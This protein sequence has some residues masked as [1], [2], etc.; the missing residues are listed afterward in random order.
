MHKLST[1]ARL[2]GLA[3]LLTM[4]ACKPNTNIFL[5]EWDTPYG[6]A[7]FSQITEDQYL[8]A[9]KAG[10]EEARKNVAAIVAN[11]EAPTFENTVLAYENASPILDKVQ[12]VFFNLSESDST[13]GMQ[14]IEEEVIPLVTELIRPL[15]TVSRIR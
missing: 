2:A 14:A 7:P 1:I 15:I 3:L 13:P 5:Q 11:P 9:F 10:I 8:P 12:G 4:S 6:T